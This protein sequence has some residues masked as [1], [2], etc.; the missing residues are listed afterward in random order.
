MAHFAESAALSKRVGMQTQDRWARSERDMMGRDVLWCEYLYLE[1][2]A[3]LSLIATAL[4]SLFELVP[5][6]E[7]KDPGT[8]SAMSHQSKVCYD[9][10]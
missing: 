10:Q 8:R 4:R 9:Q 6:K 3:S 1:Y 7:A 5:P 2:R